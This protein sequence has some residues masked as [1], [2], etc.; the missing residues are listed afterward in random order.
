MG[1]THPREVRKKVTCNTQRVPNQTHHNTQFSASQFSSLR[2]ATNATLVASSSQS[3]RNC[4]PACIRVYICLGTVWTMMMG[5]NH[6]KAESICHLKCMLFLSIASQPHIIYTLSFCLVMITRSI[7]C[8]NII[9]RKSIMVAS[10]KRM[11]I[12][13]TNM[14]GLI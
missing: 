12:K 3:T 7:S 14:K 2:W 1:P 4:T 11:A 9:C 8:L 10:S 13:E 5:Y 6:H